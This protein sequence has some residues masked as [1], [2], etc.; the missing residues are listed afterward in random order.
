[1]RGS[2]ET[3]PVCQGQLSHPVCSDGSLFTIILQP[4]L[5][6]HL[7]ACLTRSLAFSLLCPPSGPPPLLDGDI[8]VVLRLLRARHVTVL[9][10]DARVAGVLCGADLG[11]SGGLACVTEGLNVCSCCGAC[12]KG[13]PLLSSPVEGTKD[14]RRAQETIKPSLKVPLKLTFPDLTFSHLTG[15]PVYE[16][17]IGSSYIIYL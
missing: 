7:P 8:C 13:H 16:P 2:L 9:P 1:M 3:F 10:Q 15:L 5:F 4:V 11:S 6:H 14:D 12:S 17:S